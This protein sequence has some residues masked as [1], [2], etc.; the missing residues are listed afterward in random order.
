MGC[1]SPREKQDLDVQSKEAQLQIFQCTIDQIRN[2]FF[3]LND[4]DSITEE[5]LR[6]GFESMQNMISS[7][8]SKYTGAEELFNKFILPFKQTDNS[9]NYRDLLICFYLNS[10]SKSMEKAKAIAQILHK[11]KDALNQEEIKEIFSRMFKSVLSYS[12]SLTSVSQSEQ[13]KKVI[14]DQKN[15]KKEEE[16][17]DRQEEQKTEEKTEEKKEDTQD[18]KT[19]EQKQQEIKIAQIQET[20]KKQ[21]EVYLEIGQKIANDIA[22][23]FLSKPE[24]TMGVDEFAEKCQSHIPV[25][26]GRDIM[27]S[28][29]HI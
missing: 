11:N 23:S 20:L 5:R 29:I 9:Y 28:L 17:Q 27:L 22:E 8:L 18:E 3:Y 16:K 1:I 13:Q 26:F 24:E 19:E 21:L 4:G 12:H 25:K 2:G 14:N 15:A 7:L 6:N 10:R